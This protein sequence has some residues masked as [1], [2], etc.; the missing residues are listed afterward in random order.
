MAITEAEVPASSPTGNTRDIHFEI[1]VVPGAAYVVMPYSLTPA[2]AAPFLLSAAT[3]AAPV[4]LS[5]ITSDRRTAIDGAW[6]PE[7]AG[8]PPGSGNWRNNPQFLFYPS[9]A[10]SVTFV[11]RQRNDMASTTEHIGFT[12]IAAT[13]IRRV[14]QT[15]GQ[16]VVLSVAHAN[17]HSVVGT[18]AVQGMKERLGMPYIV[19]PSLSAA[20]A[21]AGFTLEVVGNKRMS[22][23]ELDP[24]LDFRR[25]H[26]QT[27]FSYTDGTAGGSLAFS[28]WRNNPQYVLKFPVEKHGR[29]VVTAQKADPADDHTEV[30]LVLLRGD[31]HGHGRQRKVLIGSHKDEVLAKSAVTAGGFTE[32]TY[33][34]SA[35][36]RPLIIMPFAAVP[37]SELALDLTFYATGDF[38]VVPVENPHVEE[39]DGSWALG[40]TAGG[41]RAN[42][43]SWLNNPFLSLSVTRPTRLVI[44]AMQ[45]PKGP[46]RPVVRR[47]GKNRVAIPPPITNE[48][49]RVCFG[50]DVVHS[51][52]AN[53][54]IFTSK[55]S[56][57]GE[58]ATML[59]L[60]PCETTPYFIVPH[61]YD[62]EQDAEWKVRVYADQPFQLY[63]HE[64][65]RRFY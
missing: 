28:S 58:V 31:A 2:R 3:A 15:D 50:F 29:L 6:T 16:D 43:R 44:V 25:K 9:E 23:R 41:C 52:A 46:E 62:S 19:V 51:D 20:R 53:T 64:K 56:F 61:T 38:D 7:T 27:A 10:A 21:T 37:Y 32:L 18:V 36:A 47:V 60:P 5:L 4:A 45:Y 14:M 54:P 35:S 55:H 1:P 12:V 63:P 13:D 42:H 11:L 17:D 26:V 34:Y 33:E 24:E 8:G 22:L 30:G 48:K 65:E 49:N 59:E 40:M 39:A 57:E